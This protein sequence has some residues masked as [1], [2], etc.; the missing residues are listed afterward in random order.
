MRTVIELRC[1]PG[2]V[3]IEDIKPDA[4]SRDD[5][6]AL[7][8][9]IQAVYRDEALRNELFALLDKHILPDRSRATGRPGMGLWSVLV[10]GV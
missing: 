2:S 1:P 6:P 9:G 5:I 4:K 8:V 3:P 7:P 10:M